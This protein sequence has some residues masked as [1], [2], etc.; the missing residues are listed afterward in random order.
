MHSKGGGR[1]KSYIN[2]KY[3]QSMLALE[4]YHGPLVSFKRGPLQPQD[5]RTKYLFQIK[6]KSY[7]ILLNIS[8]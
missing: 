7:Q 4:E 1:I 6:A 5:K 3:S 8:N 2:R